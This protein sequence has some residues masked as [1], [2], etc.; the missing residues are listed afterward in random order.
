[1][2]DEL[3][4]AY[5]AA[6]RDALILRNIKQARGSIGTIVAQLRAGGYDAYA[7]ELTQLHTEIGRVALRWREGR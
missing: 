2:S 5:E 4:A 1:M 6:E 3:A 7:D